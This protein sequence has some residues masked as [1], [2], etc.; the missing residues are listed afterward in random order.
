[1]APT[2]PEYWLLNS[3]IAWPAV[4]VSSIGRQKCVTHRGNFGQVRMRP[5]GRTLV[6][7]ASIYLGVTKTISVSIKRLRQMALRDINDTRFPVFVAC[8]MPNQGSPGAI[9]Q[10]WLNAPSESPGQAARRGRLLQLLSP[11]VP[12]FS[13]NLSDPVE[14]GKVFARE[15]LRLHGPEGGWIEGN[16][17]EELRRDLREIRL[18]WSHRTLV[19]YALRPNPNDPLPA[20]GK[21]ALVSALTRFSSCNQ[22]PNFDSDLL[23]L[24]ASTG[25]LYE[26]AC[27]GCDGPDYIGISEGDLEAL[28]NVGVGIR[29]RPYGDLSGARQYLMTVEL[30][31]MG[32]ENEV[33]SANRP[34][35]R[36]VPDF[37]PFLNGRVRSSAAVVDI[38]D[39]EEMAWVVLRDLDDSF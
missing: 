12:H 29:S 39:R 19:Y 33:E 36:G 20:A 4:S 6:L 2:V 35:V 31:M 34:M 22:L 17:V 14:E 38:M 37:F 32:K 16:H 1:M 7:L 27:P 30:L 13:G 9:L 28:L 23:D 21:R 24:Y 3:S 26:V 18:L 5:I 8:H 10:L 25:L 15:L 11:V